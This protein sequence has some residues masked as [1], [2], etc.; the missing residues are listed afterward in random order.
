MKCLITLAVLLLPLQAAAQQTSVQGHRWRGAPQ[1]D[2]I[3]ANQ[4]GAGGL[5]LSPNTI[6][7]D[8]I[9]ALLQTHTGENSDASFTGAGWT[10]VSGSPVTSGNGRCAAFYKLAAGSEATSIAD[11]GDHQNTRAVIVRRGTFNTANP[12]NV[13]AT[14]SEA[15]TTGQNLV[16]V[17]T[18][19][20]NVLVIQ[21]SC[22]DNPDLATAN[23]CANDPANSALVDDDSVL[24]GISI[25]NGNEKFDNNASSGT[26]S[27]THIYA[28]TSVKRVA[29][30]TGTTTTTC[31]DS[32]ARAYFT[33]GIEPLP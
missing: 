32:A 27:G 19:K 29:G 18:T 14:G 16:G 13:S 25:A 5:T 21:M 26:L 20:G 2:H 1:V 9:V 28:V 15:S 24:Q 22:G 7:G 10:A 33:V 8:F 12:V 11:S 6:A 23:R 31:T 3:A 4:V 30:A 17:T